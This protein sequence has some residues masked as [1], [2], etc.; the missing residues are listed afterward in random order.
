MARAYANQTGPA[1]QVRQPP[2]VSRRAT[3]VL[4]AIPVLAIAALVYLST[5]DAVVTLV[6]VGLMVASLVAGWALTARDRR[7]NRLGRR[8][9]ASVVQE[10]R[11][12]LD[13]ELVHKARVEHGESAGITEI[14]RQLP[15]LTFDQAIEIH[16]YV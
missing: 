8:S 7:R 14:R 9:R 3:L 11:S 16:R 10:A 2:R 6:I 13:L 4:L 5:D 12:A 1:G 15:S